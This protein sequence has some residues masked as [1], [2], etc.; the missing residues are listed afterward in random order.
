[1]NKIIK[2]LVSLAALALAWMGGFWWASKR[3]ERP[4]AVIMTPVEAV[5]QFID[6]K[7]PNFSG[8]VLVEE[9]A[10]RA[11]ERASFSFS[12]GYSDL[13]KKIPNAENTIYKIASLSKM[14]TGVLTKI[15]V[16]K[17][18]IDENAPISRYVDFPNSDKITVK[19][20]V[21]NTSG[22]INSDAL[23]NIKKLQVQFQTID[24]ALNEIKKY[25]LGFEP[26]SKFEYS[27][28]GFILLTKILEKV[29][30][31]SFA[32]LLKEYITGPLGMKHTDMEGIGAAKGYVMVNGKLQPAGPISMGW[33]QGAG[34]MY[35]TAPDLVKFLD[36]MSS[37]KLISL[38]DQET[39]FK[40]EKSN[41]TYGWVTGEIDGHRFIGH[42]GEIDGF[43]STLLRFI[44]DDINVIVL[45]NVEH[46]SAEEIAIGIAKILWQ[47][48]KA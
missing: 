20:L 32:E 37:G 1:M 45:N 27:N 48:K 38:K 24:D 21:N 8:T 16:K 30:G 26:G 10:D 17:G 6:E 33:I 22:I 36:G 7:F 13:D 34:G 29:S 11:G 39:M 46:S 31:K 25:P 42:T 23:P 3:Y 40:P 9:K 43:N 18:L 2:I 28:S 4:I 47:E 41:Y 44:K 12:L 35:S 15:L 5:T 19:Q 14:F